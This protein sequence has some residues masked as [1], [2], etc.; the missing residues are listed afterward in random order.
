M[1]AFCFCDC[2]G[3][4]V[5]YKGLIAGKCSGTYKNWSKAKKKAHNEKQQPQ[6]KASNAKSNA[7]NNPKNNPK[8]H[9]KTSAARLDASIANAALFDPM[10]YAEQGG[11][12]SDIKGIA[13][14]IIQNNPLLLNIYNNEPGYENSTVNIFGYRTSN[15]PSLN[16]YEI[17]WNSCTH[18]RSR[19]YPILTENSNQILTQTRLIELGFKHEPIKCT[20]KVDGK[21]VFPTMLKDLCNQVEKELHSTF[22]PTLSPGRRLWL[23][24]GQGG[25]GTKRTILNRM[26]DGCNL[27]SRKDADNKEEWDREK[28]KWEA[29]T[30]FEF[31]LGIMYRKDG[32]P[33]NVKL[34]YDP[35]TNMLN[36]KSNKRGRGGDDDDDLNDL[37]ESKKKAK[38]AVVVA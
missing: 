11:A 8:T 30:N 5:A 19:S 36:K 23:R 33:E 9:A 20:Y 38:K 18:D 16:R 28:A 22:S 29:M 6:R 2:C 37:T 26:F 3:K 7:K 12:L 24:D 15:I 1:G 34:Q 17:E 27:Q 31:M 14:N 25:V 32:L 35:N 4:Q 21:S 13:S 10:L